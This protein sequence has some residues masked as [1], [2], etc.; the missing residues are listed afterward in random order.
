MTL[1]LKKA[2]LGTE[3]LET[4]IWSRAL[5]S[6]GGETQ[7]ESSVGAAKIVAEATQE[8]APS[9]RPHAKK[10]IHKT[11]FEAH[12][13]KEARLPQSRWA[14]LRCLAHE[15]SLQSGRSAAS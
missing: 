13:N 15:G 7:A 8:K 10:R 6:R 4:S 1:Q 9:A 14:C 2:G 11:R 5:L 12:P 3:K